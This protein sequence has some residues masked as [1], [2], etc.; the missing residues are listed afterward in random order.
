MK[1]VLIFLIAIFAAAVSISAQAGDASDIKAPEQVVS[2]NSDFIINC[3]C[4]STP[5]RTEPLYLVDGRDVPRYVFERLTSDNI[6]SFSVISDPKELKP[7]GKDGVN[8]VIIIKSKL[9]KKTLNKMIKEA[10]KNEIKASKNKT[11]K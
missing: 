7:Y 3:R 9:S 10:K 5:Y 8:G 11:T 6:E 1:K 2:D 4:S